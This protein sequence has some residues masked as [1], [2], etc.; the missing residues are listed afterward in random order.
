MNVSLQQ[1]IKCKFTGSETLP[2]F[3][4]RDLHARA[5]E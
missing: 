4:G 1:G 3:F 5:P 2:V